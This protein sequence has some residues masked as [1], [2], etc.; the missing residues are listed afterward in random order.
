MKAVL[1][2]GYMKTAHF[3]VPTWT[4]K[5]E[6]T[7]PMPPFSTVI[8]MVHNLCG[9]KMY[10]GMDISIAGK[11]TYNRGLETRWKGGAFSS[12]ETVDF[13][14]RFP[15]RIKEKEGFTGWVDVPVCTDFISDLMLRL[16]IVTEKEEDLGIIYDNM[17]YPKEYPSLGKHGDIIRIDNI[18][19]VEISEEEKEIQLDY[20]MYSQN[21]KYGGTY[22]NLHKNYEI[23]RDRRI[24]NNKR[25]IVLSAGQKVISQFDEHGNPVFLI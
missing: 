5:M 8:G 13:K 10:H 1:I 6:L 3:N 9:W 16:H 2:E 12:K 7:Y 15:V 24:F 20:D 23:V 21:D 14:K 22:Y 19:T 17:K 18:E 11:G 25:V 4:G